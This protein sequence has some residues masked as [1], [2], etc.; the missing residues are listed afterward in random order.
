MTAPQECL[1]SSGAD[2]DIGVSPSVVILQHTACEG[3]GIIADILREKGLALRIVRV[4]RSE[5]VPT[6]LDESA[7][8][9][10]LGGPM[11]VR[12]VHRSRHLRQELDLID[13][14]LAEGV[15]VLGV[16][17][18]SQLLAACLGSRVRTAEELEVGWHA[19]HVLRAAAADALWQD[20]APTFPAFHWHHDVFDLPAGAVALANSAMTEC[21]AFRFGAHAYGLLFHLEVNQA[22]IEAMVEQ[23]GAELSGA[24]IDPEALLDELPSR[25]AAAHRIGRTV[26]ARWADL[27]L[28]A[29]GCAA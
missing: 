15:P 20:S 1:P 25:V 17:L 4:D 10:A 5:P 28:A 26:F 7:A 2:R 11:S 29:N 13:A 12:E 9:I 6:S 14:A 8:V 23:F 21:Q 22:Q 18:G 24:G 19:V 3:P 27:V 16:C